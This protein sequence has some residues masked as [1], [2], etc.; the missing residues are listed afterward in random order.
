LVAFAYACEHQFGFHS[1][2]GRLINVGKKDL[3]RL[4]AATVRCKDPDEVIKDERDGV[5]PVSFGRP[6]GMGAPTLQKIAKATYKVDLTLDEVEQRIAA[7]H[8]LCPELDHYLEDDVDNGQVIAEF[9]QLTP[10]QFNSDAGRWNR[11]GDPESDRPQGW[12]GGMLLK[13]LRDPEP[14]TRDGRPYSPEEIAYF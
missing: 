4:I 2:M 14:A 10:A 7:Y 8:K 6:G 5:K 3:H 1:E 11:P 13:V 12:L 9:L